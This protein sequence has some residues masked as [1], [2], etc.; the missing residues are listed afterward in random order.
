MKKKLCLLFAAL[1]LLLCGYAY[2][3]GLND[4]EFRATYYYTGYDFEE[5]H[6][7]V[8]VLHSIA[9]LEDYASGADKQVAEALSAY[10]EA[11]FK[12]HVLFVLKVSMGSSGYRYEVEKVYEKNGNTTFQLE[13]TVKGDVLFTGDMS[14]MHILVELD[15]SWDCEPEKVIIEKH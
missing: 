10:D 11:F 9:E 15:Q 2:S 14:G 1:M 13:M 12:S 7:Q 8:W 4:H 5:P 6:D 3:R